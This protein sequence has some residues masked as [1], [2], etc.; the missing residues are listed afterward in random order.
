MQSPDD[1]TLADF[2][3]LDLML[4]GAPAPSLDTTS[5]QSPKPSAF[6][7][8]PSAV[9]AAA[10]RRA[11]ERLTRDLRTVRSSVTDHLAHGVVS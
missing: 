11:G 1:A 4:N 7:W 6:C 8:V 10:V 2:A 9:R 3:Y 5:V